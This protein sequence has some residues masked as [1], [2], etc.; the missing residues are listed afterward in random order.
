MPISSL[1][2]WWQIQLMQ[3]YRLPEPEAAAVAR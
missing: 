2:A 3:R 1:F